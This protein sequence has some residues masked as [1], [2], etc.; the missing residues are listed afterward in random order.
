M[1][2][3]ERDVLREVADPGTIEGLHWGMAAILALEYLR[4]KGYVAIWKGTAKITSKGRE[5]LEKGD[6][7]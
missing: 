1:T 2:P 4:G 6:T 5:A 7:P 3:Y